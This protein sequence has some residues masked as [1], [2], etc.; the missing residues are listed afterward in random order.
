MA[1]LFK[2]TVIRYRLP[3]GT[4]VKKGT[5]GARKVKEKADK[6]YVKYKDANEQWQAKAL[7]RDKE[8]AKTMMNE[9]DRKAQREAAGDVDHFAEHRKRP[10]PITWTITSSYLTGKGNVKDHV[11]LTK[12]R[13]ASIVNGCGFKRIAD[14][15][16]SRVVEFL[17]GLRRNWFVGCHKQ[18]LSDGR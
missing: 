3:D 12:T 9:V 2:P 14:L 5:P 10:W 11:T 7:C 4:A 13:I 18:R 8:A 1:Y 15:N 16:A 17:A 6:W